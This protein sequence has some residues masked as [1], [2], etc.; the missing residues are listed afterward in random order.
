MTKLCV[1][2]VCVKLLYV[3]DGRRRRAEEAEAEE[4]RDTES[5]TRTPHKVVGKNPHTCRNVLVPPHGSMSCCKLSSSVLSW[6]VL[7]KRTLSRLQA[8]QHTVNLKKGDARHSGTW[9]NPHLTTDRVKP[10]R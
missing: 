7:K 10:E 2:F 4:A 1:K 6:A 3:R 5:K 8:M 9:F